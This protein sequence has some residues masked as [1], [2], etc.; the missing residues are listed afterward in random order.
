[1]TQTFQG[2]DD[3][4]SLELLSMSSFNDEDTDDNLMEFDEDSNSVSMPSH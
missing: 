4:T 2:S 1:M 3:S